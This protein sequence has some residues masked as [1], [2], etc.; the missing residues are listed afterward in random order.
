MARFRLSEANT[1]LLQ[2]MKFEDERA[3]GMDDF[4]QYEEKSAP[5]ESPGAPA[6]R[7]PQYRKGDIYG[8]ID[9]RAI[10]LPGE[11]KRIGRWD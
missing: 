5:A 9:S 7:G 6:P 1:E 8:R 2:T 10:R 4:L 11:S 3:D